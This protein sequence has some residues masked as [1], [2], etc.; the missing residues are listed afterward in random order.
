VHLQDTF[1]SIT[2]TIYIKNSKF[3]CLLLYTSI[4]HI[5]TSIFKSMM[6]HQ[7]LFHLSPDEVCKRRKIKHIWK[8]QQVN[9]R[10]SPLASN[11]FSPQMTYT[12][13]T[14]CSAEY[15]EK[16]DSFTITMKLC[17]ELNN[18]CVQRKFS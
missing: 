11:K 5:H 16:K 1:N 15:S 17:W 8:Q 7:N 13:N 2:T 10:F 12:T 4:L 9:F 6:Q 18:P 3:T 14:E